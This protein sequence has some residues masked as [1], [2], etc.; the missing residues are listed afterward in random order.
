MGTLIHFC[1]AD[2]DASD[3]DDGQVQSVLT[4][5]QHA[6]NASSGA[7]TPCILAA[8]AANDVHAKYLVHKGARRDVLLPGN[9][10]LFHIA[11]DLNLVGTL[12]ALLDE[13]DSH[14]TGFTHYLHLSR[15][16]N[17]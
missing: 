7:V 1:G 4:L 16:T 17:N 2:M 11:A 8:A 14:T 5:G 13:A 6:D 9:F 15:H 10:T 3:K 12:A